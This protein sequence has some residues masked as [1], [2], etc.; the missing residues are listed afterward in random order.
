MSSTLT[1]VSDARLSDLILVGHSHIECMRVRPL[2]NGSPQFVLVEDGSP[3]VF[4]VAVKRADKFPEYW[5][6]VA[7]NC[8][9]RTVALSWNGN[10]HLAEFLIAPNPLFD[11]VCPGAASSE[12]HPR[13]VI[14]PA[15]VLRAFFQHWLS[16][17]GPSIRKLKSS[18]VGRV[19]VLGTPAPKGS[20]EFV[21]KQIRD[22]EWFRQQAQ[23]AGVE[24]KTGCLTPISVRQKLWTLVQQMTSKIAADEG[25]KFVPVPSD[26]LET[27]RNAQT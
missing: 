18:A 4:T 27:G 11:F 24:L 22:D 21:L 12:L 23:A 10:Q 16:D 13:A 5:N 9:G 7:S 1:H 20:D 15:S 17:L 8:T 6:L 19:L 2:I 3:R 26:T 25:A 14:L